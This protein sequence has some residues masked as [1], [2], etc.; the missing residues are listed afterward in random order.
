M[1]QFF[2]SIL[3]IGLATLSTWVIADTINFEAVMTPKEQFQLDFEDGSNHFVLFVRRE[4]AVDGAGP[5]SGTTATEFGMHDVTRGVGGDPQGYLVFA[6][7]AGEK[8]YVK[9]HVR[10]I[11][12]PGAEKPRLVDYGFWEIVGGTGRFAGLKGIGSMQIKAVTKTDRL[13][14]FQ[15]EIEP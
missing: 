10:A 6:N 3:V 13:F 12:F 7:S 14:S 9:W 4:G 1:K 15:G 5:L 11:F 2:Q 8:A